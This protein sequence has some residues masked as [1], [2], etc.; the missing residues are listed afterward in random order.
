MNMSDLPTLVLNTSNRINISIEPVRIILL[1][2]IILIW[3][4]TKDE[5]SLYKLNI[6]IFREGWRHIFNTSRKKWFGRGRIWFGAVRVLLVPILLIATFVIVGSN[7]FIFG[8]NIIE[9]YETIP[10]E[11][12]VVS[13]DPHIAKATIDF[14]EKHFLIVHTSKSVGNSFTAKIKG[15]PKFNRFTEIDYPN[16]FELINILFGL[17]SFVLLINVAK[18]IF[19][20]WTKPYFDGKVNRPDLDKIIEKENKNKKI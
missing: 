9:Y 4:N 2:A 12:V 10:T 17:V 18:N 16:W 1:M 5:L 7:I 11:F 15:N 13:T 3:W 8:K 19:P 20:S 6:R 14:E